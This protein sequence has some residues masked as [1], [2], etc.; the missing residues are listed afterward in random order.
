MREIG[1]AIVD[2]L[3]MLIDYHNCIVYLLDGETLHAGRGPRAARVRGR[4]IA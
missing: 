3:R 2:E 1:E 4:T